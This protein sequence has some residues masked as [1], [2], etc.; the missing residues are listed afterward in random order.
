MIKINLLPWRETLR[1]KK[2]ERFLIV[3]S[4]SLIFVF[5]IFVCIHIYI[6]NQKAFQIKRNMVLQN[7]ITL[8]D[9]TLFAIKSIDEK[10]SQII[11]KINYID[12]LQKTRL[13]TLYLL[14]QLT[15]AIPSTVFLTKLTRIDQKIVIEGKTQNSAALSEFMQKM[16][17]ETLFQAPVLETMKM[18]DDTSSENIKN[19]DKIQLFTFHIQQRNEN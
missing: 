16:E 19:N 9:Q 11:D 10:I 4:A 5:S 3:L 7:E 14:N 17:S 2:Q 1:K 15:T 13:D 6:T 8:Q 12:T 18:P